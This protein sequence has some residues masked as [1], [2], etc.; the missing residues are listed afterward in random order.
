MKYTRKELIKKGLYA[1]MACAVPPLMYS[2][3]NH[4]KDDKIDFLSQLEKCIVPDLIILDESSINNLDF[5][6]LKYVR[7]TD[8]APWVSMN[9]SEKPETGME[10]RTL[11]KSVKLY[12]SKNNIFIYSNKEQKHCKINYL[13]K[14]IKKCCLLPDNKSIEIS[15]DLYLAV[16]TIYA[17]R[18]KYN[19]ENEIPV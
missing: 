19:N 3:L 7:D 12:A 6:G 2:I 17:E 4:L 14:C 5:I 15:E 11:L 1:S 10:Y 8:N 9:L 16:S 13:I 18:Y